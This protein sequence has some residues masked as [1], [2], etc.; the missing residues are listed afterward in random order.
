M[1]PM[2]CDVLR[3]GFFVCMHAEIGMGTAATG[4]SS[5]PIHQTQPSMSPWC[6]AGVPLSTAAGVLVVCDCSAFL[7]SLICSIFRLIRPS[8]S[9]ESG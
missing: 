6:L 2:L 8:S 1:S 4:V 5:A 7:A 9:V 3:A